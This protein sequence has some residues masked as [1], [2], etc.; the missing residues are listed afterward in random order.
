MTAVRPTASVLLAIC[1]WVAFSSPAVAQPT[2]NAASAGKSQSE[3]PQPVRPDPQQKQ[4]EAVAKQIR[5]KLSDLGQAQC[6]FGNITPKVGNSELGKRFIREVEAQLRLLQIDVVPQA[7]VTV[8]GRFR[9]LRHR[10]GTPQS[11][12]RNELAQGQSTVSTLD[13]I[14][15]FTETPALPANLGAAPPI[16]RTDREAEE[17]LFAAGITTSSS[18]NATLLERR[19]QI[20]Q[21]ID[22]PQDRTELVKLS[23][24]DPT[25]RQVQEPVARVK[26]GMGYA[27]QIRGERPAT[28][29]S[30]AAPLN[31]RPI[32]FVPLT[33]GMVY[34]IRLINPLQTEAV[35]RVEIDNVSTFRYCRLVPAPSL[36]VVLPV[37]RLMFPDGWSRWIRA[38][39]F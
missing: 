10:P 19:K 5:N 22:K 32:G 20:V 38:A 8:S 31:D 14:I 13:A 2:T 9:D 18:P 16:D 24:R 37:V 17:A 3:A 7:S 1:G 28:A 23:Y 27:I 15:D 29:L 33:K 35:A 21:L 34:V 6:T 11:Q 25:G 26:D 39:N 30:D 12:L 4:F 36:F